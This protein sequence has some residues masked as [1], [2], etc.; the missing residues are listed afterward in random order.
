MEDILAKGPSTKV[1]SVKGNSRRE[2]A[3]RVR[4]QY[5]VLPPQ[6]GRGKRGRKAEPSGAWNLHHGLE[7][8][9]PGWVGMQP[10]PTPKD[11]RMRGR[12]KKCPT[13]ISFCL[14]VSSWCPI[15]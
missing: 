5:G 13:L 15:D 10:L 7:Q 3:L 4:K 9:D 6:F 14:L 11:G 1:R 2:G 12:R 8:R